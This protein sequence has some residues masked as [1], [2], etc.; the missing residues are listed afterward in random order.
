M[1]HPGYI[2]A[3]DIGTQSARTALF[4]AG[5]R[6]LASTGR[7]YALETPAPGWAQQNPRWWWEASAQNIRDLLDRTGVDPAEILCVGVDS[8]MH[9]TIPIDQEGRVL[10]TTVQ[11]WCDKRTADLV[12][13]Y[14]RHPALPGMRA[15]AGN[16]PT[17]A[18]LGFKIA[19]LRQHQP[20]VYAQTWKF[21]TGAAYIVYRLTGALAISLAEASGSFCMDAHRGTWSSELIQWLGIDE[22][23]LPPIAPATTIAGRI[24][25]AA[26]RLTGL[27]EGTPVAVGASD[28]MATLLSA[29]VTQSGQAVDISGTS[30]LMAISTPIPLSDVPL[31]NLRHETTGWIT[32]G[33]VETGGGALRWFRDRFCQEELRLARQAQRDVYDLLSEQAGLVPAGADGVLFFPYLLGERALGSPHSRGVFFGLTPRTDRAVLV[34]AILEGVI[35]EQRRVLE[36]VDR[37]GVEIKQIRVVGGGAANPL[38]N[39][40]RADIYG[41]PV[42]YLATQEGGIRGT[43]MLA[44]LAAGVWPDVES[45]LDVMIHVAGVVHPIP[46]HQAQY[47][48]LFALFKAVHNLLMPGFEQLHRIMERD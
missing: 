8:Q 10:V 2:L 6:Q 40:I 26:A 15:L 38:W 20:E 23:K 28:F 12:D 27:A 31:M 30:C 32:F 47:S 17:T 13:D 7:D 1:M 48:R 33:V 46:E 35:F 22:R 19:W 3:M 36:I 25:P 43:A 11:L 5:G 42:V 21:L 39:Q 37:T 24:T 45:A 29:G 18:W 16:L 9:A 34:R 4:D 14:S 41:R 44:G